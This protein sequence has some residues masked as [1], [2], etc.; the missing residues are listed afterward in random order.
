[1][2][3]A[4]LRFVRHTIRQGKGSEGRLRTGAFG[5][6]AGTPTTGLARHPDDEGPAVRALAARDPE[7]DAETVERLTRDPDP[8][9]REAFAGHP[10]LPVTR[11]VELLDD[12]ELASAAAANPALPVEVM[13]RLVE[14]L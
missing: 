7:A 5:T 12:E 3:R 9:V 14:P 2:S 11:I 8:Q 1:M 6:S 13:R 4:V 10:R